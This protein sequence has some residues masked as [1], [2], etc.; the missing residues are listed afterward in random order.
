MRLIKLKVRNI[1]S[2]KGEHLINFS[3]IQ[4]AS[5]L[6]AITGETG[7]G[8]STLLNSI[9]LV[10]YGKVYKSGVGQLDLVTLGEKE[11]QIDLIFQTQGKTY[12]A[13]WKVRVRKQNG[14]L[15]STTPVPQRELKRF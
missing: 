12:L 10:L 14:E 4:N 15:Y 2:L 8:K 13:I 1:A 9:G 7:A 6:F 3:E 5:P 11:G